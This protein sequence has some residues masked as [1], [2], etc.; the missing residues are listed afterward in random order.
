MNTKRNLS[1]AFAIAVFAMNYLPPERLSAQE[2]GE[3]RYSSPIE[4]MVNPDTHEEMRLTSH[5]GLLDPVSL[6]PSTQIAII[7]R[8]PSINSRDPVGIAALDGG[9]II[10]P[11]DLR[12]AED[13][14][15]A[16]TFEAPSTPGLCRVTVVIGPEQY[17]LRLYVAKP[18]ETAP[19]CVTP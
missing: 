8:G 11:N 10:A 4:M 7:L 5:G 12:A 17:Q 18:Q 13:G 3:N 14:T 19:D 9:E 15:V 16:F 6:N 2:E 1:A